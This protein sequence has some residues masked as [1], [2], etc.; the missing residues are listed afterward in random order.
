MCSL[1]PSAPPKTPVTAKA[2]RRRVGLNGE[3]F[4]AAFAEDDDGNAAGGGARSGTRHLADGTPVP[5]GSA[6]VSPGGEPPRWNGS[7]PFPGERWVDGGHDDEQGGPRDSGTPATDW[8]SP[9]YMDGHWPR[10][11]HGTQQSPA[12]SPG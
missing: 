1:S 3:A 6:G 9:H 11:G 7:E 10:G 8:P 5:G 2:L 4:L 12:S